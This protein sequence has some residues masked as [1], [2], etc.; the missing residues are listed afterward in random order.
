MDAGLLVK[1]FGADS[2]WKGPCIVVLDATATVNITGPDSIAAG[3]L[4]VYAPRL[5]SGRIEADAVCLLPEESALLVVR[6]HRVRTPSGGDETRCT[7]TVID[8]AHIVAVE[9][10]NLDPLQP[11]SVETPQLNRNGEYRP[12]TLLG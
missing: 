9:F 4:K 8:F 11:L 7:L 12:G 10:A 6:E 5:A 2:G 3:G 1:L